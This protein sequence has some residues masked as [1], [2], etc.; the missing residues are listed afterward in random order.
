M[1]SI[2]EEATA[3]KAHFTFSIYSRC[4]GKLAQPSGAGDI[5]VVLGQT[6]MGS[7][8]PADP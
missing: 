5:Y 3:S 1:L 6:L 2:A 7:G 4:R 8:F